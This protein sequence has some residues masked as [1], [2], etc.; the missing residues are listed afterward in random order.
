L[1]VRQLLTILMRFHHGARDVW[2]VVHVPTVEAEEQRPLHRAWETLKHERART[3]TRLKGLRSGQGIRR[4][5]LSQL[6]EQLDALRLWD[7]SPIPRGRRRRLLRGSAHS[8]VW[9]EPSAALEAEPRAWL[10]SAQEASLEQGRQWM[11]RQG[12]GIKGAWVWVR[13]FFGWR[14]LKTRRAVGG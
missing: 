9:S 11:Q 4:T 3:T 5:R 1:D 13:A 8:Q 6:P 10:H 7:G 14:A 2:R 12:I